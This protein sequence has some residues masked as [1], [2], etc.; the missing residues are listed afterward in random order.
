MQLIPNHPKWLAMRFYARVSVKGLALATIFV[1]AA[2][3]A[4][5]PQKQSRQDAPVAADTTQ[6]AASPTM[7]APQPAGVPVPAY[8]PNPHP[9]YYYPPIGISTP[10]P[11]MH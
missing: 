2:G 3:C 7:A 4:D 6:T 9:N 1:L 10:G 8:G 5:E 11:A